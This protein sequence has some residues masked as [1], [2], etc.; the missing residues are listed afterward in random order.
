[1]WRARTSAI[2]LCIILNASGGS[3]RRHKALASS[4]S[5]MA[6][7]AMAV[8]SPRVFWAI[9]RHG[10]VGGGDG[11]GFAE[12]L[13]RLAPGAADWA[14]IAVRERRRP[15]RYSEYVSH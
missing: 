11:I 3:S 2:R 10:G 14:S 13:E 15:E 5:V 9:V 8:A 7:A 4:F 12:A 6:P 1:M